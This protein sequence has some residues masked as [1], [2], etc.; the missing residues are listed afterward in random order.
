MTRYKAVPLIQS[1]PA[2]LK[3]VEVCELLQ[4]DPF[5]FFLDSGIDCDR[6]GRYS[7]LGSDPFLTFKSYGERN[8]IRR[9]N[10]IE[11]LKGNPF[12]ILKTLLS[13]YRL[14]TP[15]DLPPFMGGAVG[16]FAYDLKH[17]VEKLPSRSKNDIN[18]PLCFLAFYDTV[19]IFDHLKGKAWISS[20]GL[21]EE[22]AHLKRI[23]AKTRLEEFCQKL[24]P[25]KKQIEIPHLTPTK[26]DLLELNCNFTRENY[27]QAVLKAKEYITAGD[28]YQVNL[29]QRFTAK[30]STPPFE[31]YKT[32]RNLN[33]APFAAY[34]KCGEST[35]ISSS[36]ERFLRISGKSVETRPIKGT[37]PRGESKVEDERLKNEL[38]Q[39][40]KDRA[41]LI[42]IVDLE[43]NDL[44]RVCK[45][46]TVGVPEAITLETYA[47]VF[48]LVSTITGELKE[49]K[50]HIDCIKACFPGG[51]ITGAPKIRSMEIIDEL[52]PTQRK[53]YTGSIGYLGF[54]QQTD[55]NIV[56]RTILYCDNTVH[57]Q[58]GGG[59][60]ADSDPELEYEETLHKGKALIEAIHQGRDI[61]I[62]PFQ[63]RA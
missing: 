24:N 22:S 38:L 11:L 43:R 56:I 30:V 26:Q 58:V 33:P 31:L 17:F 9:G 12:D 27:I 51:S 54:N 25:L 7:F 2:T 13:K 20:T 47:T 55:L 8:E 23:R 59:I 16:Y 62:Q 14:I 35:I 39:S 29:S 1:L 32:L 36:P 5:C 3:P 53:I 21:P 42:M 46:G 37:R 63:A 18:V 48:H 57:F 40:I 60:V 50:E 19:I 6:L 10:S 52:E 34:L 41:E 4:N 15:P 45:Y 61:V 49:D 44:G 28:I